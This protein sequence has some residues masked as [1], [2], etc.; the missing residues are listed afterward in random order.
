VSDDLR[1]RLDGISDKRRRSA[2]R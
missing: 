2:A 1:R